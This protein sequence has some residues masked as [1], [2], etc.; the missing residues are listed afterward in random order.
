MTFVHPLFASPSRLVPVRSPGTSRVYCTLLWYTAGV[1]QE[2]GA[3]DG[4]VPSFACP[5]RGWML[6]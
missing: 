6:Y 5:R 3:H 2:P 1:S 4:P